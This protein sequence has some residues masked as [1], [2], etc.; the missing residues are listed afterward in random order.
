[1]ENKSEKVGIPNSQKGVSRSYEKK[2]VDEGII[3]FDQNIENLREEILNFK[4]I[5]N[6]LPIVEAELEKLNKLREIGTIASRSRSPLKQRNH[7]K[8]KKKTVSKPRKKPTTP[9]LLNRYLYGEDFS[10]KSYSERLIEQ[11]NYGETVR[12]DLVAGKYGDKSY[13]KLKVLRRYITKINDE[14]NGKTTLLYSRFYSYLSTIQSRLALVENISSQIGPEDLLKEAAVNVG[15]AQKLL[16]SFD[17]IRPPISQYPLSDS[18]P[19]LP[20]VLDRI[21]TMIEIENCRI[22]VELLV[23]EDRALRQKTTWIVIFYVSGVIIGMIAITVL[24]GDKFE[25]GKDTLDNLSIPLLGVPW[26]VIV[27]SLMGSFAAMISNFNQRPIYHFGDS[28]K[29]LLTRPVQGVVLGSTFYLILTSGL[30][31]LTG[32]TVST[33]SESIVAQRVILVLSFLVGFSDRFANTV[34]QSLI[35]KYSGQGSKDRSGDQTE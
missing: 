10:E 28:F 31:L 3:K 29:W 1:M 23:K 20:E 33:Q 13:G 24:Y 26:P 19:N 5:I 27:W 18:S 35:D 32:S 14:I 7:S 11:L 16:E 34:F 15:A 30:F 21:T 2:A 4:K 25:V 12:L 17:V 22:V 6:I 8:N 9:E